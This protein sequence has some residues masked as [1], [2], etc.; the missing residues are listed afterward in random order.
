MRELNFIVMV[1]PKCHCLRKIF[2][3][4]IWRIYSSNLEINNIY[5]HKSRAEDDNRLTWLL[6]GQRAEGPV[7]AESCW[8]SLPLGRGDPPE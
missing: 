5:G 2:F 4:N 3:R 7:E 6:S 1:A 8:P